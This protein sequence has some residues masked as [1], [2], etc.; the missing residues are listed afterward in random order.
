MACINVDGTLTKSGKALLAAVETE[1]KS[2]ETLAAE[3]GSP[4][5]KIRSSLRE[6]KS[7]QFVEE[8][9]S[10]YLLTEEGRKALEKN[11]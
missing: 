6:M 3:L 7:V 11:R 1:A 5:F 4:L 10:A 2:P 9:E 8:N